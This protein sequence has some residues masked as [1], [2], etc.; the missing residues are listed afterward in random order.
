MR[1]SKQRGETYNDLHHDVNGNAN[2]G[3]IGVVQV[4]SAINVINVNVVSVVP[5][6]GPLLIKSEPIAAV[7]E[8]R[9]SVNQPRTADAESMLGPKIGTEAIVRYAAFASGTE[10]QCW[11]CLL[12]GLRLLC[13]LWAL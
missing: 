10:L 6:Y 13:A 8:A 9:I 12:S 2:A 5:T 1:E 7:L 11:L 3:I 4:I